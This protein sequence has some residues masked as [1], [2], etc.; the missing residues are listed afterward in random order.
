MK[1]VVSVVCFLV[2][3]TTAYTLT[4]KCPV[5]CNIGQDPSKIE[6]TNPLSKRCDGQKAGQF[7]GCCN[8]I[9]DCCP[10]ILGFPSA[11]YLCCDSS[12]KESCKNS[13]EPQ[14]YIAIKA[15]S[16]SQLYCSQSR[17][18]AASGTCWR[19]C[20]LGKQTGCASPQPVVATAA[21][22]GFATAAPFYST[23][24]SV[25]S[26]TT[27]VLSTA[28]PKAAVVA[29]KA[30]VAAPK[31]AVATLPS[32]YS[33]APPQAVLTSSNFFGGRQFTTGSPLSS[34]SYGLNYPQ[35]S[36]IP[37]Q[38]SQNQ[39]VAPQQ[40]AA[41]AT[42]PV[43]QQVYSAAAPVAQKVY[44][45][46]APVAQQNAITRQQFQYYSAPVAPAVCDPA[47]ACSCDDACTLRGDCCFDY[48]AF[49]VSI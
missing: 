13:Y 27:P 24:A 49:C 37:A 44:A 41:R 47:Q 42:V 38:V 4:D 8:Q 15:Q 6:A 26:T 5:C 11:N 36:Q 7:V 19:R 12:K 22:I 40:V 34:L 23:A 3:V 10:A 33:T 39:F 48:C 43:A 28:A 32:T 31:A 30:A 9:G 20:G 16:A 1:F 2:A 25:Y 45:T 14:C 17:P 29:P 46:A 35:V 18:A 21:T